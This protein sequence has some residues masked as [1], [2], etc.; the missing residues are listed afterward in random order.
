[1]CLSLIL[2]AL[3]QGFVRVCKQ[4]KLYAFL[5]FVLNVRFIS[6]NARYR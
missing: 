1:M 5:R 3:A 6:I 4:I 2:H